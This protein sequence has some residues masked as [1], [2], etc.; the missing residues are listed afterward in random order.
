MTNRERLRA[1]LQRLGW[2]QQQFAD[3]LT[4]QG[5]PVALRTVQS[6][7]SE[8]ESSRECP[9]WPLLLIEIQAVVTAWRRGEIPA[10]YAREQLE[11]LLGKKE[12]AEAG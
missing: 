3:W 2:S 5:Q 7:L 11:A 9:A 12:P 4:D 8:A 6:W 1:D 10:R